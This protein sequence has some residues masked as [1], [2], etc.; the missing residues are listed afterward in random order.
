[1]ISNKSSLN[2]NKTEYLLF[3]P[4]NVNFPVNII[5]LGSNTVSPSDS[6]KNLGVIF[7]IDM[8]MDKHISSIITSYFLQLLCDFRCI[9]LFI[10]KTAS[11]TLANVF[12]YSRLDFCN[13]LSYG[14]PEYSTHCLQKVQNKVA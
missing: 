7:Q 9:C 13:S 6:A 14:L 11:I 4:N 1:M 8:S 12:V 2:P 5:D 3:N 10:S